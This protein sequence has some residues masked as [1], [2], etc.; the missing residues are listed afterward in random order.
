MS[1]HEV[2]PFAGEQDLSPAE[3]R[4]RI[5]ALEKAILA[6]PEHAVVIEP[7]HYFADGMYAR[8]IFIPA[9]TVLTGKIHKTE[10]INVLSQG[11]ISVMTD[12][13]VKRLKAPCTIIAKP[14]T[15][16]VGYAHTD[17]VWTTF[18]ATKETDLD[19][20]E[21]ELIAPTFEELAEGAKVCLG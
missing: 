10:H 16:R 15:K 5:L 19:K 21:A 12:E 7:K 8:E 6:R 9:G 11:E 18:H 1:L 14:G 20:L 4:G 13:G 3:M 17:T 2:A